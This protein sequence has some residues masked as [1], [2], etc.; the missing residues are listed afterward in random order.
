MRDRVR[1]R[2]LEAALLQII[3]VIEQRAADEERAL[4]IDHHAHIGRLHHDVAIRRAIDQVH[5]VLQSGTAAADHRDAQRAL[6]P[7]LFLEQ[8]E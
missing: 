4:R 1:V 7:A 8:T 6:R 3:A 2:H 5:L